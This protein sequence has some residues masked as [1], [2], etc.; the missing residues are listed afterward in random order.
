[1]EVVV[2]IKLVSKISTSNMHLYSS[3]TDTVKKYENPYEIIDEFIKTRYDIYIS[4]KEY[5]LNKLKSEM[6][7]LNEKVRFIKMVID[8]V[9][10]IRKYTKQELTDLAK[11]AA[12]WAFPTK[13]MSRHQ[14]K[15]S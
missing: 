9:L 3:I 8:N 2:T 4:R 6:E 10:D 11:C 13:S 1:M 14:N 15:M 12:L 5:L 7:T